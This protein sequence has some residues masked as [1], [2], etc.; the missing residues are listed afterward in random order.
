MTAH[1]I[2]ISILFFISLVQQ[3][4]QLGETGARDS[5][6]IPL[7]H[8]GSTNALVELDAGLVP[9]QDRPFQA[10]SVHG[11]NF[12]G[13]LDEQT[14]AVALAALRR[15]DE[16][17]LE[18]NSGLGAPRAVVVEVQSHGDGLALLVVEEEA[19]RGLAGRRGLGVGLGRAVDRA[20]RVGRK[21]NG[22]L[23]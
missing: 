10:A 12:L 23:E 16:E 17:V 5:H 11:D 14:L 22:A 6:G 9:L 19:A 18:V 2:P 13:Q 4:G 20:R 3:L 21:G 1:K 15:L 8:S 7:A